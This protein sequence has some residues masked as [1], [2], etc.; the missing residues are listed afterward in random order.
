MIKLFQD[1]SGE[2]SFSTKS[3][4]QHFLITILSVSTPYHKTIKNALKRR[5]TFLIKQGWP[6]KKE[7]K[8][9]EINK[10]KHFGQPVITDILTKLKVIPT[11][12]V[13]YIVINKARITNK[14][15][16]NAPYGT[17]YNYFSGILLSEMIFDDGLYDVHLT[18]D[19]RNK[20]SSV[21]RHFQDYLQTKI[22]GKALEKSTDVNITF[23]PEQ[24]HNSY[25]LLAVDFFSWAIFR[26]FEQ[27]DNAFYNI[28]LNQL[29]RRREWYI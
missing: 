12:K 14:S 21:K 1:E 20:E 23:T 7:P 22:Y 2:C 25:G 19:A 18:Y 17:G 13:N 10:D 5:I 16:L 24:S 15:F 27:G 3:I 11:L 26:K 28:F 9:Y 29:G 4:Y 6:P 8:A